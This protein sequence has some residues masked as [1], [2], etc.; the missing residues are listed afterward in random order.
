MSAEDLIGA[1]KPLG[2]WDPAGL[3]K[4]KD[5][6]T[7][8]FYRSVELKHGRVAMVGS[9]GMLF[10]SLNTGIIPNPAFTET[11]PFEAVKKVYSENPGALAQ[12]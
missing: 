11:N 9:L 3:S 2:F 10:Q 12:V 8:Y 4:G 6:E 7:I 5:D 1:T